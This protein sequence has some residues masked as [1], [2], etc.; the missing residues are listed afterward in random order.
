MPS[1]R[2]RNAHNLRLGPQQRW[3]VKQTDI[4]HGC[5]STIKSSSYQQ[6]SLID[7]CHNMPVSGKWGRSP[8]TVHLRTDPMIPASC[9]LQRYIMQRVCDAF[10]HI[11]LPTP[12]IVE[13]LVSTEGPKPTASKRDGMI[14]L[15]QNLHCVLRSRTTKLAAGL[16]QCPFQGPCP[17]MELV[18][19]WQ[20]PE[21]GP[22]VVFSRSVSAASPVN[23]H[24]TGRRAKSHAV[25]RFRHL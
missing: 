17:N 13:L 11:L 7:N 4:P 22:F 24:A 1:G 15:A 2:G 21:S 9:L 25:T 20:I 5:T 18:H 19:A 14:C 3:Y 10:N 6:H 16:Q 8:N 12:R 23:I